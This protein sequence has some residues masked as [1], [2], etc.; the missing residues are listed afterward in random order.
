MAENKINKSFELQAGRFNEWLQVS[1]FSKA[2]R[3]SYR[4]YLNKFL[5]YLSGQ[6]IENL[7]EISPADVYGYQT[8]L[9]YAQSVYG[10][11]LSILTQSNALNVARTFFRYLTDSGQ[12]VFDPSS[13][14]QLPK[15]PHTLPTVLS[16]KQVQKLLD[17]P[18]IK[19]ALGFRDRTIMEVLYVSAI[20]N[21]ELCS[22]DVYDLDNS[23][24]RLHIREGKGSKSRMAPLGTI[25]VNYLK[26]YLLTWRSQLLHGK[27]E[28][29]L[30]LSKSGRRLN[31]ADLTMMV[32]KY[33]EMCGLH[34]RITPHVLR[35]SCA[36][37]LLKNGADIRYI[38]QLLGH[39]SIVSTQI[40]THVETGD[41]KQVHAR[42]HPRESFSDDLK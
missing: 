34:A 42:C 18:D 11:P 25:A 29:A 32:R 30:F 20:R 36:T 6:D 40:Y 37:H 3:R 23:A 24:H 14:L 33:G 27:Q 31:Q 5:N 26:E 28:Q 35:H 10:K 17:M 39:S 21:S 19:T 41:L 13:A 38:Q 8:F 22:L 7:N 16:I 15:K 4:I 2:T 12:L 1:G 9:Y